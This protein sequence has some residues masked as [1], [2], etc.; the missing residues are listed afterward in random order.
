MSH[1]ELVSFKE[2]I[3]WSVLNSYHGVFADLAVFRVV[4]FPAKGSVSGTRK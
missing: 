4:T 1:S 3:A 2:P